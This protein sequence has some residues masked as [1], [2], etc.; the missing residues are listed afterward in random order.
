MEYL[1]I[2]TI[3]DA[4]G[5]DGT[6]KIKS[7]TDRGEQRYKVGAKLFLCKGNDRREVTVES[8]RSSH[9]IDFVK[10]EEFNTPEEIKE[11]KGSTIEVIKDRKDLEV[12][13]YFYSDLE[14]CIILDEDKNELG[15]VSKVEEFPAQITLRVKRNNKPDFFV[16][17]IKQFILNVDIDKKTITIKVIG[18]ML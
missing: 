2:G 8:Y 11:L 17:F 16:P 18:G 10:F 6:A 9:V 13:Y 15:I 14:G 4:F 3:I 12:G 7:S 1:T 5:L